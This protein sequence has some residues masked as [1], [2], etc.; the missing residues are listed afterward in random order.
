MKLIEWN[1]NKR[2]QDIKT[3]NFVSDRIL[4]Q[5]ADVVCLLEY[6]EDLRI[7]SELLEKYLYEESVVGSGNQV[8]IAVNKEYAPEGIDVVRNWEEKGCYNFLHIKFEDYQ[9]KELSIIG[10]RMLTG[11][12]NNR[13]DASKQTPPLNKYLEDIKTQFVCV[14]DFNIREYR[15][16]CWFPNYRIQTVKESNEQINKVSFLFPNNYDEPKIIKDMGIIDHVLVRE[17]VQVEVEYSWEFLSDDKMY[18]YQDKSTIKVGND[19]F[20]IK[21]GL[22]DH[23]MMICDIGY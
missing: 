6:Y 11:K 4:E 7:R 2:T 14:G 1:I 5:K 20:I 3:P 18:S 23:G 12:R 9:G 19:Y 8:L 13:I 21:Q 15:M 16:P 22:P 17:A 10:L